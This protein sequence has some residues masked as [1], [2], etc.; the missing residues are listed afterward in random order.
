[1][2]SHLPHLDMVSVGRQGTAG[3]WAFL[4]GHGSSHFLPSYMPGTNRSGRQPTLPHFHVI[5]MGALWDVCKGGGP[6]RLTR[7]FSD[8]HGEGSLE[9]APGMLLVSSQEEAKNSTQGNVDFQKFRIPTDLPTVPL[10]GSP[11]SSTLR[12]L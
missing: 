10:S 1:M 8:R 6:D 11:V 3:W 9:T 2:P 7:T 12:S 5:R 4:E